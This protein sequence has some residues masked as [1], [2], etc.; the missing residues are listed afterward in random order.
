MN[1]AE[2][3][4]RK[5]VVANL[6]M[7]VI[8]GS[9]L[10]FG[11]SLRREF[12]PEVES[13]EVTIAAPY[14]GASPDEVERSLATKI[15]DRLVD[16]D[17]VKE[18]ETTI[19][20][21][22]AGITVEFEQNVD[23]GEALD[24][25]KREID[26][27]QDLPEESERITVDKLERQMPII[28]LTLFGYGDERVRKDMIR[29]MRE[30]LLKLP[31]MGEIQVSGIRTDEISV[32]VNPV[33]LVEHR[34]SLVDV[35]D[36]IRAAMTEVPGGT[37]RSPRANVSL[38][39]VGVDERVEDVRAI[40]VKALPGGHQVLLSDIA[41]VEYGFQDVDLL[42]RFNNQ[43]AVSLTCFGS[44]DQDII[45][46]A[47]MVKAYAA[48]RTRQTLQHTYAE[49]L[50]IGAAGGRT[51]ALP[52]RI[53]AYR[54][55]LARPPIPPE[56]LATDNDLSR[57]ISQRL[58]LLSRNALWGAVLVFGTLLLM[59]AP[60]V[61]WWVTVGLVISV[62]G[63]LAV[64]AWL[65]ITLNLL[66]M[67]G[68]IVVM[69]LLVDDAIVVA[70]NI[71]SHWESGASPIQAAINGTRQVLWPVV[72]TVLTT[73]AAF[74]PLRLIE[75]QLG[76]QMG[77][78]PIVVV[79]ALGVSL[80]ES[81]LILPSHMGH[82]LEK[83]ERRRGRRSL[84]AG[85]SKKIEAVRNRVLGGL[86]VPGYGRL[87]TV[88]L[89][90]RYLTLVTALA[91][92]IASIGMVVGKRL[93]FT[94]L[95]SADSEI[96]LAD[97]KMP[98]GTPVDRTD[99]VMKRLE[100]VTL[101]QPEVLTAFSGIGARQS[102]E[103]GDFIAQPH[104]AQMFVEL[105]PVEQRMEEGGRR[106]DAVRTAIL[107]ELG[108]IPDVRSLRIEEVGGGPTGAAITWAVVGDSLPHIN[109]V[110]ERIKAELTRTSGVFGVADD[111]D[112]GQRELRFTLT[113][114]AR[115]LGFT[116]R[117]V[118]TQA[119]AAVYGL[120]AYTFAG[121]R[122]DIDVRVML[123]GDTRD[124]MAALERTFIFTPDGRPVPLLEVVEVEEAVGY[125]TIRR[126]DRER[127]VTVSADVTAATNTEDITAALQPT[128]AR[129]MDENPGVRILPRGRQQDMKEAFST[130]PLGMLM[131]IGLIY[132]V[133]AWLFSSFMQPAVILCAVPFSL[134]GVIWGHV[135]LG[136]EAT[137]LSLIGLVALIGIVVNDSLI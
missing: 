120:E 117:A 110:V 99:A 18:M 96:L 97:L 38:R 136:F 135:L 126:L 118:A 87:L 21:G 51:E 131:A 65:D 122:E 93:P 85:V 56:N 13:S 24:E 2:F 68:L 101:R 132:V 107:Q 70:E 58:S 11:V 39:T 32:E 123:E 64:M 29:H 83:A 75:G 28:D 72:A 125:A 47:D 81:L 16:L 91:V 50:K 6:V 66:T 127:V 34:L 44:G 69:G 60:R 52:G 78:L 17:D 111:A 41:R 7:W 48:G 95:V 27:L 103:G 36:R 30:D 31:G 77:L 86:L 106:S 22:A 114:R 53:R 104:L 94:F 10:I 4:V 115:E 121:D 62:M 108:D 105:K 20:E 15:E 71:T 40:P 100:E 124:N 42:L 133:L 55:G 79:C 98:V 116:D 49:Q 9:G 134:V 92:L 128:L 1:I 35:S 102:I 43:P 57:F 12:F 129:L 112:S 84:L 14:P 37:I 67:F 19:T 3:G 26:A 113:P 63:T 130:L 90:H 25:V 74:W 8:I 59:L 82:S 89:R 54:A 73:V 23:L 33:A 61:A 88:C 5:P 119:R 45:A 109:T 76:D 46:I 137:F 80:L